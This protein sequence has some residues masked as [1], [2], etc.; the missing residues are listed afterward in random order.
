M[1]VFGD[2]VEHNKNADLYNEVADD[3][4][5]MS[6]LSKYGPDTAKGKLAHQYKN[7]ISDYKN[8]TQVARNECS[9]LYDEYQNSE[10]FRDVRYKMDE[11][12]YEELQEMKGN[13]SGRS[14]RETFDKWFYDKNVTYYEDK[15]HKLAADAAYD[16]KD[17]NEPT[18]FT[19]TGGATTQVTE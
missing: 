12:I 2:V 7:H 14:V 19:D 11:Y 15:L 5:V 9:K 10:K 17:D 18:H 4:F 8:K 13:E 6:F 1:N 3:T 16:I